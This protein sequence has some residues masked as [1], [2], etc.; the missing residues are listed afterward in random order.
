[1]GE[2]LRLCQQLLVE[3]LNAAPQ[4]RVH[5]TWLRELLQGLDVAV[6]CFEAKFTRQ[7]A[8]LEQ[9]LIGL[10]S[11]L[12]ALCPIHALGEGEQL[13]S[14]G[15]KP[16]VQFPN[17]LQRLGILALLLQEPHPYV[18][19]QG[20]APVLTAPSLQ[21]RAHALHRTRERQIQ[22]QPSLER[23]EIPMGPPPLERG[24]HPQLK[25]ANTHCPRAELIGKERIVAQARTP[26]L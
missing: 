20:V 18:L 10:P 11:R 26:L 17:R 6:E 22:Q 13:H 24:F 14:T 9:L 8:H 2:A 23:S 4:R 19:H 25:L 12:Q 21:N 1:M 7:L 3:P 16:A 5:C 15:T